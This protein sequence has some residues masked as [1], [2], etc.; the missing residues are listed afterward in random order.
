MFASALRFGHGPAKKMLTK[1]CG[2]TPKLKRVEKRLKLVVFFQSVCSIISQ[3][4]FTDH[5][6][7]HRRFPTPTRRQLF[8]LLG[9]PRSLRRC[10]IQRCCLH[11]SIQ[12]LQEI[13]WRIQPVDTTGIDEITIKNEHQLDVVQLLKNSTL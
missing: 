10:S 6:R 4:V 5:R 9:W 8:P 7:R 2:R 13:R 11:P 12:P 1:R 3:R